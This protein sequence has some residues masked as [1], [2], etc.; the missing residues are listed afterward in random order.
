[1]NNTGRLYPQPH[2]GFKD[3]NT[4]PSLGH[5]KKI[6]FIINYKCINLEV[7]SL[8]SGPLNWFFNKRNA[9]PTNLVSV[10]LVDKVSL[11]EKKQANFPCLSL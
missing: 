1:M 4:L 9:D 2:F 10:K 7:M 5:Y 3:A 6:K 11:K 8:Y